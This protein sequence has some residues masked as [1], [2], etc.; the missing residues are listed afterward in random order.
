MAAASGKNRLF[1]V[2][3]VLETRKKGKKI[4]CLVSWKGYSRE[5][6][7]WEP[8]E[9]LNSAAKRAVRDPRS[10]VADK[11]LEHFTTQVLH[12]LREPLMAS[13]KK[14]GTNNRKTAR[15]FLPRRHV[16]AALFQGAPK[17]PGGA[18]ELGAATFTL[19]F[20]QS[21]WNVYRNEMGDEARIQF[22]IRV[23]VRRHITRPLLKNVVPGSQSTRVDFPAVFKA[24]FHFTVSS[25]K[26]STV[27]APNVLQDL[28]AAATAPAPPAADLGAP[29]QM[30]ADTAPALSP[31]PHSPGTL[32]EGSPLLSPLALLGAAM[33]EPHPLE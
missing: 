33:D 27:V 12:V 22:P 10:I 32:G 6:C 25:S 24:N 4:Y 28:L 20:F 1:E 26:G 29:I 3:E 17:M 7:S 5:E 8:F 11:D 18:L 30:Q 31:G 23:F 15:L 9:N 19:P 14:P 2:E 21:D 16:W 13:I